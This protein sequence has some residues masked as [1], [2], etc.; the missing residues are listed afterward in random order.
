MTPGDADDGEQAAEVW[1]GVAE[2][3]EDRAASY[4][5]LAEQV[6]AIAVTETCGLARVT[7]DAAGRVTAL[8]LTDNLRGAPGG[9]VVADVMTAMRGAQARLS[10]QMAA[11]VEVTVGPDDRVGAGMTEQLR[12]RFGAPADESPIVRL[13]R[14]PVADD[15][16]GD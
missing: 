2:Q 10:E 14:L 8:A 5:R 6:E 16:F 4:E 11:L 9:Q 15:D 1:L 3:A 13:M 12:H 7:V